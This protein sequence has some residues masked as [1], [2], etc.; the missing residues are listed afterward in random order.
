ME[1]GVVN[2]VPSGIHHRAYISLPDAQA[3]RHG[4]Q[5]ADG[6]AGQLLSPGKA[7]GGGYADAHAGKGAGT[8]RHGYH[9]HIPG[10]QGQGVQHILGHNHQGLAVG[11]PRILVALCQKLSVLQQGHRRRLGGGLKG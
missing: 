8:C 4:P 9:V 6:A 10:R 3:C 1:Q 5:G 11:K 7:L 2:L